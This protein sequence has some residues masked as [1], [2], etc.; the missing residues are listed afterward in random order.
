[1]PSLYVDVAYLP[2]AADAAMLML[3][4]ATLRDIACHFS[5]ISLMRHD[6]APLRDADARR[7]ADAAA[8]FAASALF[9]CRR[10]FF[11]CFSYIRCRPP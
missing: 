3:M 7:A 10:L 4:L 5:A 2:L 1:M 11:H 8:A 6:M 9:R